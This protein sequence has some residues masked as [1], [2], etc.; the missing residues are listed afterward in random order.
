M[1]TVVKEKESMAPTIGRMCFVTPH[2]YNDTAQSYNNPHDADAFVNS[3][4]H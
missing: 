1:K 3:I 2:H 4:R